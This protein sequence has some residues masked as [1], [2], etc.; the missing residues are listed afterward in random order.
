VVGPDA[1][2]MDLPGLREIENAAERIA[3]VATRTP[4]VESPALSRRT[5]LEIYL[6][7][8]CFQPIK[9][10]KIRG[11]YNKISRLTQEGVVAASSGNHGIAVA[12]S[13]RLT[14]K[15]CT[16]VVPETVVREK[17]DAILDYGAEVVRAG[18]FSAEREAKAREI[19]EANGSAFVH[20][21]ND[22]DVIAGQGTCG[23]EIAEQLDEFDSVLV[24]VGG[25]G[26]ISGIS[27]ALKAKRPRTKV[28]GVEPQGAPKLTAALKAKKVVTIPSP[29]SMADGLMPS[30]LGN[31]TFE[32]CSRY[33]D[34]AFAVSE[35]E[36]LVATRAM[37]REARIIAE[38]SGAAPLAPL[39][40]GRAGAFGRRVVVVVSGGNISNVLLAQL[41]S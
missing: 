12:Y 9:V 27:I 38:P 39:L 40:S 33:V 14:G 15:K 16:V 22:P 31:L 21:F 13:S 11:A 23:L 10:F 19:A 34:G 26:L 18:K 30:S 4:L 32:A 28:F 5:G 25:G 41:L 2:K 3:G 8:E 35:K 6:K 36:I 17:V 29:R 24:P 1:L 7:L 37:A 20:P